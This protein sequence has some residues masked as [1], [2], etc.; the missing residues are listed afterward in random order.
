MSM[1]YNIQWWVYSTAYYTA[2][3][4]GVTRFQQLCAVSHCNMIVPASVFHFIL[5]ISRCGS[6]LQELNLCL[7]ILPNWAYVAQVQI[8]RL[9]C[10]INGHVAERQKRF[11]T[12]DLQFTILYDL[13]QM[14]TGTI[15]W[16]SQHHD[17][18]LCRIRDYAFRPS[19]YTRTGPH[20]RGLVHAA[21]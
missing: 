12:H 19:A 13:F 8:R 15:V 2:I 4:C 14:A 17:C 5:N 11:T 7:T 6:R 9:H 3:T 16:N 1:T 20:S 21:I 10:T 18:P